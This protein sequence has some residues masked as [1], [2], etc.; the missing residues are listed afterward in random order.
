MIA[1][2][3]VAPALAAAAAGYLPARRAARID[4]DDGTAGGIDGKRRRPSVYNP[5]VASGG[6]REMQPQEWLM[7][8]G[9]RRGV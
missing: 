9:V 7:S 6:P 2:T 4:S 5:W 8:V 1:V 3:T